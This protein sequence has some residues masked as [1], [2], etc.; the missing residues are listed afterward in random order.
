MIALLAKPGG[1]DMVLKHYMQYIN[2]FIS[3]IVL[4]PVMLYL[5]SAGCA[6]SLPEITIQNISNYK[7]FQNKNGVSIAIDPF[8]EEKRLDNFF[9]TDIL[10]DNSILPVHIIIENNI[11]QPILIEGDN[12]LLVNA[13]NEIIQKPSVYSTPVEKLGPEGGVAIGMAGF[14]AGG[15][16]GMFILSGIYKQVA[17]K[18]ENVESN[19]KIKALYDKSLYNK[20]ELHHGFVYLVIV[21]SAILDN[22][23]LQIK[24]KNIKTEALTIFDFNM[25]SLKEEVKLRIKEAKNE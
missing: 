22:A 8:I 2:S 4:M 17:M 3:K 23:K 7:T 25:A 5:G 21:D 20:L 24:I 6:K 12:I 9:G 16:L 1:K 11:N 10:E 18:S 14:L 19:I 13:K 15:Y